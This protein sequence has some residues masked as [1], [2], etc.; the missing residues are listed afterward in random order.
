MLDVASN[1]L[2]HVQRD[3]VKALAVSSVCRLRQLPDVPMFKEQGLPDYEA[4]T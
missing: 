4:Y 1:M 3:E 2:S